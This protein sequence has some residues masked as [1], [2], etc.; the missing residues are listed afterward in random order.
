MTPSELLF[1]LKA[2]P[3]ETPLTTAHVVAILS[4]LHAPQALKEG[5]SG[6]SS[7]DAEKLIDTQTLAEWIGESPDRLK[8]WRVDGTGPKFVSKPKHVAYRVGDVRDWIASR[9]VQSTTQADRLSFSSAWGE[10][11]VQPT[12][13]HD[14]EKLDLFTSIA[15]WGTTETEA[16]G[17]EVLACELDGPV[18]FYLMCRSEGDDRR[19][20]R[21]TKDDFPNR[22]LPFV[23]NGEWQTG[24]L[25]HLLAR[26]PFPPDEQ[27]DLLL[28]FAARG[29]DFHAMDSQTMTAV[30]YGE[31]VLCRFVQA[32]ELH[33]SLVRTLA[34]RD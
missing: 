22:H 26:Y 21:G 9:T 24:T 19:L 28:E 23:L 30:A 16:T 20:V 13:F 8:K 33:D 5:S 6:Y 31:P 11:F 1:K 18:A 14:E 10:C 17:L 25:A 34:R 3:P 27:R 29:L 2:L 32:K 4:S 7:W 12:I 15:L